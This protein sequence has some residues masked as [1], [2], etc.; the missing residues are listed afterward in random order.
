MITDYTDESEVAKYL[1]QTVTTSSGRVLPL[2]DDNGKIIAANL[3]AVVP[4]RYIKA[5]DYQGDAEIFACMNVPI[6]VEGEQ[7]K[8]PS[9]GVWSLLE[10][11]ASPFV[12]EFGD[13]IQKIHCLRALYINEFREGAAAD[14]YRWRYEFDEETFNA[15]DSDT[16]TDF[17][18]RVIH[19]STMLN[20]D[21]DAPENWWKI[22]LFFDLSFNGHSMIPSSG[23]GGKFLFGAETM[24]GIVAALGESFN[25]PFNDLLWNTP[26]I[27][28]G[29]A[30]AA[31][32]K[33]NGATGIARP[34]DPEDVRKQLI[35]AT[36]REYKGEL[37][38]WQVAEPL[39]SKLTNIQGEHENLKKE[40]E[41]LRAKAAKKA[42]K[43][44]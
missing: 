32:A 41:K 35:L 27:V 13:G 20:F 37:H 21:T 30:I 26:M 25:V 24:G 28:I 40:F 14:V 33:Q 12:A 3:P 7:I 5:A 42:G 15:E 4:G 22:R 44:V 1:P 11:Y 29:H 6:M 43:K 23:G 17:D 9:L 8:P 31:K 38:P 16:W 2:F 39:R 10:T 18:T 34:K 19:Y 36:A